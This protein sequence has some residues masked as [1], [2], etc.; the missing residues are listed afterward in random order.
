MWNEAKT[1]TKQQQ[2]KKWAKARY[3]DEIKQ[4]DPVIYNVKGNK[5]QY[6]F[7]EFKCKDLETFDI[8]DVEMSALSMGDVNAVYGKG[9]LDQKTNPIKT[10]IQEETIV[11]TFSDN[12]KFEIIL[13]K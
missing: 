3:C 9:W 2:Q 1:N 11:N 4:F 8:L 7:G 10:T 12:M 13:I 6:V 5:S